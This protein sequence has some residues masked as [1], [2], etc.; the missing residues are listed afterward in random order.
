MS[1]ES[2]WK[3]A[4]VHLGHTGEIVTAVET[5]ESDA[6]R[7]LFDV[8]PDAQEV[9]LGLYDWDF[10]RRR[11]RP[12][13]ITATRAPSPEWTYSWSVP[14]DLVSVRGFTIERPPIKAEKI[15]YEIS[16][17]ITTPTV[18]VLWTNVDPFDTTNYLIYTARITDDA[19]FTRQYEL[20]LAAVLAAEAAIPLSKGVQVADTLMAYAQRRILQ[21]HEIVAK[22]D[23]GISQVSSIETSR[24]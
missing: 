10:A 6:Q 7:V 8:Y 13:D 18:K 14:A 20:V 21:G 16:V 23:R 12:T 22:H 19:Y 4:L 15:R 3:R 17:D 5:P 24:L 2:V 11:T 1:H 9:A